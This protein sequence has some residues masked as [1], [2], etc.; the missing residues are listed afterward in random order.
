[1]LHRAQGQ[2]RAAQRDT[3]ASGLWRDAGPSPAASSEDGARVRRRRR[4]VTVVAI[5]AG[6]ACLALLLAT[7]VTPRHAGETLSGNAPAVPSPSASGSAGGR[8]VTA[9]ATPAIDAAV[10]A[11]KKHPKDVAA[12]LALAHAYADGGAT[13]LAAIEYLAVARL[14][15]A[16]AEAN[17]ALALLAFE[18]GQTAQGKTMVDRVL[19][20]HPRYPEALYVRALIR[21]MGLRQP[22]AAEQDLNAYLAAAPFGSHR[23]AAETLLALASSQ[24]QR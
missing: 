4:L 5:T 2:K 17:T 12:H 19:A 7:A 3:D 23:T 24:A 9:A 15:P 20:A 21:L 11:V 18:V 10:A 6:G 14:D 13:Q 1:M 16:N 22:R 8:S